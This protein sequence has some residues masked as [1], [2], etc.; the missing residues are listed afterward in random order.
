MPTLFFCANLR[1]RGMEPDSRWDTSLRILANPVWGKILK[2]GNMY[3]F[4]PHAFFGEETWL[5]HCTSQS[6]TIKAFT[7][8]RGKERKGPAEFC[9]TSVAIPVVWVAWVFW[10]PPFE[11]W[12]FGQEV[13]RS[14]PLLLLGTG[15]KIICLCAWIGHP[16]AVSFSIPF[17]VLF[18]MAP[19]GSTMSNY[20]TK[21]WCLC[22]QVLQYFSVLHGFLQNRRLWE[23]LSTCPQSV[24]CLC[25]Q[26]LQCVLKSDGPIQLV[27]YMSQHDNGNAESSTNAR[28]NVDQW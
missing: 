9:V 16:R 14:H 21:W 11:T 23:E 13:E 27:Y 5:C 19:I 7:V 3:N 12:H 18:R 17:F 26:V 25:S 8:A 2:L 4:G 28:T 6:G 20:A 1:L 22:L 15:D 10:S 24:W